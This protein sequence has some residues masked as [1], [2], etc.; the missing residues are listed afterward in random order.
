MA[1]GIKPR[2][3]EKVTTIA[4]NPDVA[5][6][7]WAR[8][9]IKKGTVQGIFCSDVDEPVP[10]RDEAPCEV[11][12]GEGKHN[13]GIWAGRDRTESLVGGGCGAEGLTQCGML[14]LVAGMASGRIAQ[15]IKKGKSPI[16]MAGKVNPMFSVD[17]ARI[18]IT[19]MNPN[20]DKA[21]GIPC[22]YKGPPEVKTRPKSEYKS[23][24]LI[25]ADHTR[26]VARERV[27]IIAAQTKNVSGLGKN[28]ETTSNGT[29]IDPG[30]GIIELIAGGGNEA[31][32]QPMVRGLE[33]KKY[34]EK[35]TRTLNDFRKQLY[36]LETA[37]SQLLVAV[38]GLSKGTLTLKL[39][40]EIKNS[41][42]RSKKNIEDTIRS[43]IIDASFYRHYADER[44]PIVF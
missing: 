37:V 31:A 19:Q 17:A 30:N 24:V 38:I 22:G 35:R 18:Y 28:G 40:K 13:S 5:I 10:T 44:S 33:L 4:D 16:D 43:H 15:N 42:Q 39:T 8:K 20:I 27:R 14:D 1:N 23:A 12:I 9:E 2:K 41:I 3:N 26:I 32:L 25:K 6:N 7:D 36:E 11:R 34:L 29:P 21:I